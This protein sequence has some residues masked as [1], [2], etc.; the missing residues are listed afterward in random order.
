MKPKLIHFDSID[1]KQSGKLVVS[2]KENLPFLPKRV[3]WVTGVEEKTIRGE[4]AHK[5]L[6]QILICVK[7]TI[8]IELISIEQQTFK[9]TLSSSDIGLFVPKMFWRKINYKKGSILLVLADKE[10]DKE[11]YINNFDDFNQRILNLN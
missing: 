4:H 10:Y 3:Y 7:G 5:K 2:E 11:D 8:E 6:S 1:A 9:Y